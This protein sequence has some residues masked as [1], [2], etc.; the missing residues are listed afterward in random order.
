MWVRVSRCG[1]TWAVISGAA[2]S[3]ECLCQQKVYFWSRRGPI[4]TQLVSEGLQ[5]G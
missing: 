2:S 3:H 5:W 1:Q 4:L